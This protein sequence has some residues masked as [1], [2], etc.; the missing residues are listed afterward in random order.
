MEALAAGGMGGMGISAGDDG[1]YVNEASCAVLSVEKC[2]AVVSRV[3]VGDELMGHAAGQA[4]LHHLL[5]RP[6]AL[7]L[8]VLKMVFDV[9]TR[10][11]CLA[12]LIPFLAKAAVQAGSVDGAEG[13]QPPPETQDVDAPLMSLLTPFF[14]AI[15]H[16]CLTE[17]KVEVGELIPYPFTPPAAYSK[18]HAARDTTL[19]GAAALRA[20]QITEDE[21]ARN[22]LF[23]GALA[24]RAFADAGL[25]GLRPPLLSCVRSLVD[26]AASQ[27]TSAKQKR[28]KGSTQTKR[29]V[30]RPTKL[31]LA[32]A[33]AA[34][35]IL[36]GADAAGGMWDLSTTVECLLAL[37]AQWHDGYRPLVVDVCSALKGR[38]DALCNLRHHQ[39]M[40]DHNAQRLGMAGGNAGGEAQLAQAYRATLHLARQVLISQPHPIRTLPNI[41]ASSVPEYD[42][43]VLLAVA[44]GSVSAVDQ[45]TAVS[46]F[47]TEGYIKVMCEV[48][49]RYLGSPHTDVVPGD[50][51]GARKLAISVLRCVLGTE[52]GDVGCGVDSVMALFRKGGDA[53]RAGAALAEALGRRHGRT[54]VPVLLK[55]GSDEAFTA[56]GNILRENA[57]LAADE[58][59]ARRVVDAA[60]Q[61]GAAV[62][63]LAMLPLE[64]VLPVLLQRAGTGCRA[65]KR[66]LLKVA[67]R[68]PSA[69][70][71]TQ[72]V[73]LVLRH[74]RA[75]GAAYSSAGREGDATD[76][77][78]PAV[79]A[80]PADIGAGYESKV[81]PAD[82][83][84]AETFPVASVKEVVKAWADGVTVWT[85]DVVDAMWALLFKEPTEELVVAAVSVF[86]PAAAQAEGCSAAVLLAAVLQRLKAVRSAAQRGEALDGVSLDIFAFLAPLLGLR[87]LP[88][89]CTAFASQ[90]LTAELRA[91]AEGA[92]C[93]P[94]ARRLAWELLARTRPLPPLLTALAAAWPPAQP[95]DGVGVEG[96]KHRLLFACHAAMGV[97]GGSPAAAAASSL[98]QFVVHLHD[99]LVAMGG[100]GGISDPKLRLGVVDALSLCLAAS[101]A[102]GLDVPAA[103]ATLDAQLFRGAIA[104][105][106]D[107]EPMPPGRSWQLE[108]TAGAIGYLRKGGTPVP[109]R[110]AEHIIG[111][112]LDRPGPA[113]GDGGGPPAQ[114]APE[115][116]FNLVYAMDARGVGLHLTALCNY[117]LNGLRLRGRP[118]HQ[119]WCLKLLAS[120]MAKGGDA[121]LTH[122]PPAALA[123]FLET[124]AAMADGAGEYGPATAQLAAQLLQMFVPEK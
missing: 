110:F 113:A 64:V 35:V 34:L 106:V 71:P 45:A 75:V 88:M 36:E 6:Q 95:G 24:L 81:K 72:L 2:L 104:A 54:L 10:Q 14:A 101:A 16:P 76:P 58:G 111:T 43:V 94:E 121:M 30:K 117:A 28:A 17:S 96:F 38:L 61:G 83:A 15:R 93:P 118:T 9:A 29:T 53:A 82:G 27:G 42:R 7:G 124:L 63:L 69:A 107:A 59:V 70:F 77:L 86:A 22:Q 92:W 109:Q 80:T 62:D 119:G 12:S 120:L 108:V 21:D 5:K 122:L 116:L 41:A 85:Q 74:Q 11:T 78:A 31:G 47:A 57:E 26:I 65:S 48:L 68:S 32:A 19:T 49:L 98:W 46:D 87:P 112:L 90:E 20:V 52:G 114:T 39:R 105:D 1:M 40:A 3:G 115:V 37:L 91:M 25:P 8:E 84:A 102:S 123:F 89:A 60:G 4:L 55:E 100:G 44:Y 23:A 50:G 13:D 79:P 51:T 99:A 33:E 73:A 18:H 103:L 67:V 66:V 97:L 56:A